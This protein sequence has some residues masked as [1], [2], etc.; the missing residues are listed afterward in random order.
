MLKGKNIL[1]WNL[2]VHMPKPSR[3]QVALQQ[4]SAGDILWMPPNNTAHEKLT[5][6]FWMHA[7]KTGSAFLHTLMSFACKRTAAAAALPA[8]QEWNA[9]LI[10]C[11]A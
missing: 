1:R 9:L 10:I 11:A 8:A 5:N 3:A 2:I 6:I 4:Q 7:P